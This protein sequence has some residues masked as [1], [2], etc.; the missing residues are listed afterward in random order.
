M[1]KKLLCVVLVISLVVTVTPLNARAGAADVISQYPNAASLAAAAA[2]VGM[3]ALQS[4][5][6]AAL[7]LVP[8]AA[9]GA[10][11]LK[12]GSYNVR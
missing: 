1:L 11:L 10:A 6:A 12:D 8:A 7:P 4:A 9:A 5:L 3:P 2:A